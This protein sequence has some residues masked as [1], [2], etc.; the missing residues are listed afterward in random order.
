[1]CAGTHY[2]GPPETMGM[3]MIN[4]N[5]KRVML[6]L[7][8]IAVV[9]TALAAC[10]GKPR[11]KSEVVDSSAGQKVYTG[12][13]HSEHAAEMLRE[14]GQDPSRAI[15]IPELGERMFARLD[16]LGGDRDGSAESVIDLRTESILLKEGMTIP[17]NTGTPVHTVLPL[18]E[19]ADRK[20]G[21]G[22]AKVGRAE[23]NRALRSFDTGPSIEASP[24]SPF[25][26]VADAVAGDGKLEGAEA[27]RFAAAGYTRFAA[28]VNTPENYDLVD[29]ANPDAPPE[30]YRAT[31]FDDRRVRLVLRDYGDTPS[32]KPQP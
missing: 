29:V 26:G 31:A 10:A 2:E 8:G 25:G 4:V 16:R 28:L 30:G 32:T 1:M 15:S 14:F 19:L 12:T 3:A 13:Y 18:L 11:S 9:G 20:F 22:D 5:P 6:A 24:D 17:W 21:N 7:G 27:K 23:L